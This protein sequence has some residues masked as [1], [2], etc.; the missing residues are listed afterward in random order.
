MPDTASK[1]G[2]WTRLLLP[3]GLYYLLALAF[4][5]VV[6]GI[7]PFSMYAHSG[8]D[9]GFPF[10][11]LLPVAALG[12]A[13]FIGFALMIRL[14]AALHARAASTTTIALFCLGVFLLL[15]HVYA[16]IQT[17]PL[18][19]S[20]IVSTEPLLHSMIE[21]GL[22]AG[23]MLVFV[24]LQRGRGLSIAALFSVALILVG[25]G[26]AGFLA[27]TD[28][29]LQQEA[30]SAT[31][32]IAQVS[33]TRPSDLKGNIYH[34]V[35]DRMQTDAFLVA[36]E[37]ASS[38]EAFEGFDLFVKNISNYISTIP[39]SASYLTGTLYRGGDYRY[40]VRQWQK[41]GLHATLSDRGYEIWMFAPFASWEGGYVDHFRYNVDIYEEETGFAE[42]GLYDL[43]HL[44]L[45]SLAP[46]PL[47]NEALPLAAA[48]ADPVFELS[49]GQ[50]RPLSIAEGVDPYS[51]VLMLRRLVS[52][53][54]LH[55]P[56]GRYV[57]AH[58]ALPHGPFVLDRRCR[59]VGPSEVRKRAYLAQAQCAVKLVAQ[60]LSEL[61]RLG[62][63]DQAT[64]VVHADT[65]H[66]VGGIN[67]RTRPAGTRT[68][69]ISD[70]GLVYTLNA[71]LMVKRPYAE[72]PLEISETPTQLVDLFP[73]MLDILD[74]EFPY[75]M[76]GKSVFAIRPNE[77]REARFGFDPKK[78]MNGPNIVEVRIEDPQDLA[79][80][81]LTVLGPV[82]R[83]ASRPQRNE[84]DN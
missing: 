67:G 71:L 7:I 14:V 70:I 30:E 48:L 74:L 43:I 17:G 15:A 54:G 19:G 24:Q 38:A 4:F 11:E 80:S 55:A 31:R 22:L 66:G 45:A 57:Y 13:L 20:K 50:R 29:R 83:S 34:I 42:T 46:N 33:T 59:Y 3:G 77:R 69:G 63:Y 27:S 78:P 37:K 81:K 49:T 39:S 2:R 47:T 9:W 73:T 65:G 25:G 41:K 53:E 62:R 56:D 75:E 58:P 76:D 16:P 82:N 64:I 21:L 5:V 72:G 61:K 1:D 26:Y 12:F 23:L 35:L 52:E 6:F 51:S 84:S 18:D 68:E 79:H 40:W 32:Q 8:E 36:L 28:Q 10:S 44:W 60:F